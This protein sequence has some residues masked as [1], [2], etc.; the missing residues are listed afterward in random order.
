MRN[1]I[2]F[3]LCLQKDWSNIHKKNFHERV[4]EQVKS[5]MCLLFPDG[6]LLALVCPCQYARC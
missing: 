3:E 2:I 1:L 6:F 4:V 5:G